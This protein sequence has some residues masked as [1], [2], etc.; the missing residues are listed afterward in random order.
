MPAAI[1]S[2]LVDEQRATVIKVE[3]RK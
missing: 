2:N 1:S 3:F